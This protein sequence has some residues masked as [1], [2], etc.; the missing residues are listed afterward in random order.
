M[1]AFLDRLK[2]D[3]FDGLE[4]EGALDLQGWISSDFERIFGDLA[5]GRVAPVIIE[6]GTWK[7]KSCVAMATA[8]ADAT[9]I[10][11]DTWL[12]A[13]EFWTYG[14]D[15]PGLDDPGRGGSLAKSRGYPGVFYT[16]TRN[17]KSLGLHDRVCPLPLSSVQAAEVLAFHGVAADMVYVDAS[18]EFGAVLADLEAYWPLL[19]P[20][21]VM[22]GDDYGDVGWPGVKR[23][24]HEFAERLGLEVRVDGI[25]W[26]IQKSA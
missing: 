11:V 22:F 25:V 18:H 16:F 1:L 6:V 13:P 19:K 10:A 9:V 7:G 4:A 21:G 14:L 26:V 2:R 23:A 8:R 12:G 15:D 3:A 24:V 5:A 20:G 17:V